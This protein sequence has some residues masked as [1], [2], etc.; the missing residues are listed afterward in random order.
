MVEPIHHPDGHLQHPDVQ[1]ERSDAHFRPIL[2]IVAAVLIFGI[3]IHLIVMRFFDTNN[4]REAAAKRSPYPLA[5]GPS[6]NRPREPRLEQIDRTPPEGVD[7]IDASVR[8]RSNLATLQSYG[9]T[10][11]DGYVHVPIDR[12]MQVLLDK[13]TL[14]P[15]PEPPAE[16]RRRANGLLDAGEPNAGRLFKDDGKR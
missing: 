6:A 1:F 10:T 5:P 12:A 16:E 4:E 8:E 7:P 11:Q 14:K 13:K 9:P 15:R 3:I 2:M